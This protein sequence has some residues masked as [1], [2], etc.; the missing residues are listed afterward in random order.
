MSTI[1]IILTFLL[2]YEPHAK[3]DARLKEALISHFKGDLP[4]YETAYFDFNDDGIKDAFI[5][6][7]DRNWCGSGG[8]TSLVFSGK[9]EGYNYQ[10]KSTIT[11]KPILVA[12][13]TTNGWHDLI[14]NTG[15]IGQ[16]VLAFDGNRYPLNPS[17]QPKVT[18]KQL[19]SAT[20]ILAS[21]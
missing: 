14:V 3:E 11:R 7:N 5:Y 20:L 19:N 10:S 15:G 17:M 2:T 6:V 4:H 16:V 1:L 9:K 18:E 8:C 13:N 21:E 12:L